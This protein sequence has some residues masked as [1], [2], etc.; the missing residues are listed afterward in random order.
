MKPVSDYQDELVA[1]RK[2]SWLFVCVDDP[3]DLRSA[4]GIFARSM[5]TALRTFGEV[6]LLVVA[7]VRNYQTWRRRAN[8]ARSLLFNRSSLEGTVDTERIR[9]EVVDASSQCPGRPIFLNHLRAACFLARPGEIPAAPMIYVAQ[10]SEAESARSLSELTSSR[11][12]RWILSREADRI[13]DL[14]TRVTNRSSHVLTLTDEDSARFNSTCPVTSLPPL[15]EPDSIPSAASQSSDG[16][17]IGLISSFR[18]TPKRW[19]AHWILNEVMPLVWAEVPQARLLV[20]GS[21]ADK[22]RIRNKSVLV[23]SDVADI[24]PYY[25][26]ADVIIVPDRQTSGLKFKTVQAALAHKA[27]VSTPAG[28]EGTALQDGISALVRSS[29]Q[30]FADAILELLTNADQR[31]ILGRSAGSVAEERFRPSRVLELFGTFLEQ[32]ETVPNHVEPLPL[33]SGTS[34]ISGA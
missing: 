1:P 24:R 4:S 29:A 17:T 12:K 20:V 30:G 11:I 18:W 19:N 22:L 14:E 25:H 5:L 6:E 16:M 27:I 33:E 23:E 13:A 32:L 7:G 3:S 26:Q 28:I 15:L 9:R 2:P 8:Q 34:R 21:G 31:R 10:N